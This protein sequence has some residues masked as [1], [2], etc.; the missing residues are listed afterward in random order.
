M[1]QL[2]HAGAMISKVKKIIL[3]SMYKRNIYAFLKQTETYPSV[4]LF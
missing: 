1:E 4:N 3:Q 2:S